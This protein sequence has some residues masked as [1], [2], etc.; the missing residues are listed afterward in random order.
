MLKTMII[1]VT[2][3]HWGVLNYT[4]SLCTKISPIFYI[5]NFNPNPTGH[6]TPQYGNDPKKSS[7]NW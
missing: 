7:L 1:R 3:P 2:F 6:S 5:A 4:D